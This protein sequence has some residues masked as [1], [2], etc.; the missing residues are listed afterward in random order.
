MK[1]IYQGAFYVKNNDK[2]ILHYDIDDLAW[3]SLDVDGT[4]LKITVYDAC[5]DDKSEDW[6][7]INTRGVYIYST[8]NVEFESQIVKTVK[9]LFC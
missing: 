8:N 3:F 4:T 6:E 9:K 5:Y 1:E 2:V 7:W